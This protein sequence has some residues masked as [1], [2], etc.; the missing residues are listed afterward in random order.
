FQE[1]ALKIGELVAA[2]TGEAGGVR[3]VAVQLDDPIVRHA[4]VLVQVVDVLGDHVGHLALSGE[5]R[6]GVVPGVGRGADP[7]GGSAEG[8]GPG[9]ATLLLV[10]H[11]VV[12][13]DRLHAAPDAAGAAEI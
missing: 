2:L 8:A 13:V 7:A 5:A 12:E 1:R 9:L 4:A 11:E 10:A 3:S 6:D